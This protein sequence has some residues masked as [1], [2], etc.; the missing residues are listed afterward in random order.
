M[1]KHYKRA[2][3]WTLVKGECYV[4]NEYGVSTKLIPFKVYHIPVQAWHKAYN[5]GYEEAEVIEIWEGE[6]DEN[7]IERS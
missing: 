1:Q 4:E 3:Y 2:E 5:N 6:S 7:D